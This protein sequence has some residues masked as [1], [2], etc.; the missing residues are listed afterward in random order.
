MENFEGK[1][2]KRMLHFLR[3]NSWFFIQ[4]NQEKKEEKERKKKRTRTQIGVAQ[5]FP[6]FFLENTKPQLSQSAG[7][8]RSSSSYM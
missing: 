5:S 8:S 3:K 6:L 7:A 4:N 2:K 1:R